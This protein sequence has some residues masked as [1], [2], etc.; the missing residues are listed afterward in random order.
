MSL[1]CHG[2]YFFPHGYAFTQLMCGSMEVF[3]LLCW[4]FI[5]ISNNE[6]IWKISQDLVKNTAKKKRVPGLMKHGI[7]IYIYIQKVDAVRSLRHPH[8]FDMNIHLPHGHICSRVGNESTW[9]WTPPVLHRPAFPDVDST[10]AWQGRRSQ[11]SWP[12]INVAPQVADDWDCFYALHDHESV[13]SWQTGISVTLTSC[14]AAAAAT[15]SVCPVTNALT[16]LITRVNHV[17]PCTF[18][19]LTRSC[20][21]SGPFVPF[22]C[23][24]HVVI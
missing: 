23:T 9:S 11:K 19:Y 2:F 12:S 24:C 15:A 10:Q 3:T 4:K 5:Y 18:L 17:H 13:I 7:Y 8:L 6:G 1:Y 21:L 22:I 14:A 20:G 16:L